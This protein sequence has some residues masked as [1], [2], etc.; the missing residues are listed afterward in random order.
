M[1]NPIL[2]RKLRSSLNAVNGAGGPAPNFNDGLVLR[3]ESSD[4]DASAH[5]SEITA[6][7]DKSANANNF[8]PTSSIYNPF[9]DNSGNQLN[10]H[11]TIYC[12]NIIQIRH[13]ALK[14]V[15]K[16]TFTGVTNFTAAEVVAIYRKINDPS[17]VSTQGAPIQLGTGTLEDAWNFVDGNLYTGFAD[18]A[19]PNIGNPTQDLRVFHAANIRATKNGTACDRIT[20]IGS[21]KIEDR[22]GAGTWADFNTGANS[23]NM[24]GR[25]YAGATIGNT[26]GGYIAAVYLWSKVLNAIERGILNDHINALWGLTVPN[27]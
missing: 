22:V 24:I 15:L 25:S 16:S 26:M 3:L 18:S 27:T 14:G 4:F 11:A 23:L 7:T 21:Q 6:W 10:G 2:M 12:A 5:N 9:V 8:A 13:L 19:R 17:T 1:P 20:Y